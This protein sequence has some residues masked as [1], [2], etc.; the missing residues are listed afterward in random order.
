MARESTRERLKFAME[1]R[2]MTQSDILRAAEPLCKQKGIKLYKS[3]L[4]QYIS[5]EF[6]PNGDMCELLGEVLDVNP[7]W[8]D[9]YE[10]P[11]ERETP[12][13]DTGAD[14]RLRTMNEKFPKLSPYKQREIVALIDRF[15]SER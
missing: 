15:L 7:A 10:V 4:S 3:K 5:G 1:L 9:G 8:I 12:I 11:M 14:E 2:R 6:K 13:G